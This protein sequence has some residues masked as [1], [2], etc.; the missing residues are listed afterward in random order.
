MPLAALSGPTIADE[1]ARRL[2]ATACAAAEDEALARRIQSTFTCP[3]LRVYTNTDL[4]G[5]ELAGAM[6]NVIAIAAGII[7]GVGAGDNAKAA[8]LARGLAEITRLGLAMGAQRVHL[9]RPD[10]VGGPCHDVHLADGPQ[11]LLRRADRQGPDAGAGPARRPHR[12]SRAS[13]PA[14]PW[15]PWPRGT[16]SRCRSRRRSTRC[17]SR[18]SPCRRRSRT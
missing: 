5:V 4:I 6:K 18:A 16:A 7:D 3:W 10:R 17:S 8:L 11:P 2:P 9:R 1:L 13:P 15:W 12:S 14:S